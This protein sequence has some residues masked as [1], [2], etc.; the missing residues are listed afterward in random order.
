MDFIYTKND[1]KNK[2]KNNLDDSFFSGK[3]NKTIRNADL[4]QEL[5]ISNKKNDQ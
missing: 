4:I 3:I 5:R 1:I 2:L